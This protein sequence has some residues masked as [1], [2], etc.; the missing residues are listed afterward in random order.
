M[1]GNADGSE[2]YAV[3]DCEGIVITSPAIRYHGGKFRLAPWIMGHFPAHR[4][5]VEPSVQLAMDLARA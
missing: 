2:E 3:D 4:I 1:G 5:Y